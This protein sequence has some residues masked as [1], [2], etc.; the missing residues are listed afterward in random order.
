M[1]ANP[2][3]TFDNITC[4]NSVNSSSMQIANNQTQPNNY[5]MLALSTILKSNP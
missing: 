5:E 2:I 4:P 3:A 1:Y